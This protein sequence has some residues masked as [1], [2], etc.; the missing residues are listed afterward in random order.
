M[1]TCPDFP[2]KI[3]PDLSA[4]PYE[5]MGLSA[6]QKDDLLPPDDDDDGHSGFRRVDEIAHDGYK[7]DSGGMQWPG[8]KKT[9][10]RS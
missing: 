8:F 1:V 4:F 2:Q 9:V 5:Q 7:F 6:F 10:R 3:G